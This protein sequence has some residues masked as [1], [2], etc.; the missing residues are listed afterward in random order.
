MPYIKKEYLNNLSKY[1]YSGIDK[2]LL[3]KYVLQPYWTGLV[4]LFPMWM[5][6]NL[7]TLLGFLCV[8]ANFVTVMLLDPTLSEPVPSWVYLT[9]ALGLWVYASLDA[10]DGK[11]ARRTGT[12]GPLGEMFDH[13][14]DAL[15]TALGTIISASVLGIGQSWWTLVVFL[16][17]TSN[18]YLSTWEEYHT[19]TLYLGY[20][21][22]PVEG[23]VML[24]LLFILTGFVDGGSAFWKLSMRH[25]LGIAPGSLTWVPDSPMNEFFNWLSIIIISANIFNSIVTV[26]K[27]SK[28]KNESPMKALSGLLPFI[29]SVGLVYIWLNAS[30]NIVT[31]HSTPFLVYCGCSFGYMVGRII[32]AHVT[33]APFPYFHRIFI[34]LIFGTLNA[35]LPAY[36]QRS[37]IF[38][39]EYEFTYIL[40]ALTYSIIAYGH[41]AISVINDV[42]AYFDI[43]C[44]RIKHPKKI[45]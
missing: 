25:I 43:W 33:K 21:S 39:L 40:L 4:K 10:I 32:L 26:I 44:L 13:G 37:P 34:P 35:S 31:E 20:F 11:Q 45:D 17:S 22:G 23:I 8:V 28:K 27:S 6:P 14:C 7:I 42:C 41:F 16:A 38:S 30:P 36:F 24:V 19:G 15:N 9:Y 3:S 2:S 5:A 12:S 18:F 29:A 1:Q